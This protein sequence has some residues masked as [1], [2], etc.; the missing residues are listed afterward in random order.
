MLSVADTGMGMDDE[1]RAR[2][3]E[4]FFTTKPTGKG[5]GLGLATVYGIVRQSGGSITVFSEPEKGATFRI[6]FPVA[7]GEERFT[8][9]ADE[10]SVPRGNETVLIAEDE[11]PV[12]RQLRRFLEQCGYQVLEAAGGSEAVEI[13]VRHPGPIELLI[14]DLAMP[15]VSGVELA[16][17]LRIQREDL[18]VILLSGYSQEMYA[19]ETGSIPWAVHVTK[20]A[21]PALIAR[22]TREVLDGQR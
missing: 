10:G 6:Y 2:I 17:R 11:E 20:P 7:D 8:R 4:P 18:R 15:G 21:D 22:I 9:T 5:T 12:R 16:R 3:F 14:T 13:A 1:T 19:R